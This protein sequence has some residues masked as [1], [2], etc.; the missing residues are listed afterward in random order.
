ML[1]KRSAPAHPPE[2]LVQVWAAIDQPQRR[3]LL[4]LLLART[5]SLTLEQH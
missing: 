2:R 5:A 3:Q 4:P 1:P